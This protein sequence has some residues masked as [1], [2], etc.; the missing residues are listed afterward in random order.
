MKRVAIRCLF[1]AL[2]AAVPFAAT[3]ELPAGLI[4]QTPTLAPMLKDVLPAVVNISVTS[5]VEIQNPLLADPF[6]RKFFDIPDQPQEREA[7]AIGSGVIVD[8]AKGYVLTN[9]HVI[10][11]AD[12]IKVTLTDGRVLD[13]KLVGS[14]PDSDLALVQIKADHLRALVISDSDKLQVGDF[15][16]A[17]GNPFAIGQTVTSGIVSTLGRNGIGNRYENLIQT[18]ASINPGNS[19]GALVN[20]KG[21]L[22]GINSQIVSRTGTSAGIGFAIPANQA[23]FVLDQIIAHGSVERGRIGIV[24][25]SID[26]PKLAKALGLA[27]TRGAV[28][29]QVVAGSPADKAGIKL[30]DIIVE[31]NGHELRDFNELRNMVGLMRVG[32]KL[33]LK[34]LRDGRPQAI[35]V[36]VGKDTEQALAGR[37]LHPALAGATFAPVDESNAPDGGDTKG[38]VVKRLQRKSPAAKNGLREGDIIIGVNRKRV[39]TMAEFEQLAGPEQKQLL[40]HIR[41]G[42][43]AFFIAV[44]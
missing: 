30:Q 8:A 17:I 3:A 15:V 33:E 10:E 28:V 43:G 2:I 24:G 21:E 12:T 25:Q 29:A 26:D 13:A 7:M 39:E 11:Q 9:H 44:E 14:D 37:G 36:T 42:N 22:I 31:A 27:N 5:K 20:L 35:T 18:D 41:R 6:F 32:D 1:I 4:G 19:G 23:R 38:I 34:I 40:L 16:V